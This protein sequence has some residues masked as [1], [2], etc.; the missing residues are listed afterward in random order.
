MLVRRRRCPRRGTGLRPPGRTWDGLPLPPPGH[1]RP[2]RP[3]PGPAKRAG[4]PQGR[5]RRGRLLDGPLTHADR[6]PR[7]GD[8]WADHR[9]VVD[10]VLWRTPHPAPGARGGTCRWSTG[11]GRPSTGG[12]GAGRGT[13]LGPG[14]GPAA[15]GVRRPRDDRD[16]L[17]RSRGGLSTKIH[18]LA[19]ARC[20]PL[21]H[22]SSPGQR[23]DVLGS[24]PLMA[25]L[26][27]KDRGGAPAPAR[28][29]SWATRRTPPQACAPTGLR[30]GRLP[31][32]EHRRA[33]DRRAQ[34]L[35][36]RRDAHRRAPA[37]LRTPPPSP[38]CACG[39]ATPPAPIPRTRPRCRAA[40]PPARAPRG[41]CGWARRGGA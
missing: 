2:G 37:R 13:A 31:G 30:P 17:G 28:T 38:P 8:R 39:P 36:R 15:S 10:G 25:V 18:L 22:L 23:C 24:A 9:T 14:A 34:A 11:P 6:A 19:D 20:R 29:G 40:P 35:P 7:R 41:L 3:R 12:I 16:G 1:H 27:V 4:S 33:G 32:A 26:R 5:R 21:A